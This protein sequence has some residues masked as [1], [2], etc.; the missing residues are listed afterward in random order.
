MIFFYSETAE[1]STEYNT[2]Q[3]RN[4]M[5]FSTFLIKLKFKGAVVNLA[6]PLS[7]GGSLKIKITVPLIKR[8]FELYNQKIYF[9]FCLFQ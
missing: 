7:H 6:Y 2:F 5:I 9:I 3:A 1:K 8:M 4:T